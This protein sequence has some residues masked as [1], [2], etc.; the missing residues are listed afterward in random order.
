MFCITSNR[1][2]AEPL[3]AEEAGH[4][5]HGN[6]WTHA[7][8]FGLIRAKGSLGR[9]NYVTSNDPGVRL[10]AQL[11]P[12]AIFITRLDA[13]EPGTGKGGAALEKIKAFA[14]STG[15][16]VDLTAG[17]DTP[18]LQPKLNA[19]YEKHGFTKTGDDEH[20]SYSWNPDKVVKAG[21]G[22]L[23]AGDVSGEARDEKG[24]WTSGISAPENEQKRVDGAYAAGQ[25]AGEKYN[26]LNEYFG[27]VSAGEEE[28]PVYY[29]DETNL[30]SNAFESGLKGLDKLK[31]VTAIRIGKIPE[32]GQSTNFAEQK[33]EP[34]VSV[35]H[36]EG[37]AEKHKGTFEMFNPGTKI[38]VAG[39]L[40]HQ[41]GSD[42]EPLL[43]R[44]RELKSRRAVSPH[45]LEAAG[46]C[47]EINSSREIFAPLEA[48][49][50]DAIDKYVD[51]LMAK[52]VPHVTDDTAEAMKQSLRKYFQK[53]S[54][55][56]I[57]QFTDEAQ[58]VV[59]R[60]LKT[61]QEIRPGQTLSTEVGTGTATARTELTE[62]LEEATGAE[63]PA[64]M[65]M[66][67]F[68]RVAKE[69][70]FGAGRFVGDNGND[71][72]VQAYP[73]LEL[74]RFDHVFVPRGSGTGRNGPDNGWG[75]RFLAA[76]D[77]AGDDAA[78]KVFE[79]TG[80]MV[81]LRD[82]DVWQAL[83]DGAGGYEDTL[84]NPF[85][86]FAWNSGYDT[87]SISRKETIELGLMDE[88][89]DDGNPTEAKPAEVDFE[90][91][92]SGPSD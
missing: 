51:Q 38:R 56:K 49:D 69:V 82:S 54:A 20:P 89:D 91:L 14:Q 37:E 6:Q 61:M 88:L 2:I 44:A 78:A 55:D 87:K 30:E 41:T 80:R 86:P 24:Q 40:H 9:M 1:E 28:L 5:F 33:M 79:E 83:G 72:L 48:A 67:F 43:V 27:A 65:N 3:L 53:V 71:D 25:K 8:S 64:K 57:G 46:R 63:L 26:N 34:G 90:N 68:L 35:L 32:R 70:A 15:R 12:E 60:T 29:N 73:A 22:A 23:E 59:E 21:R 36:L 17:A 19:F 45:P 50:L 62:F 31:Y 4:E 52:D 92:F 81:A 13:V 76:C 84:G 58:A 47:I 75:P 10:S 42:G 11:T 39:W 7:E 74:V 77:E 66:D 85:A 18:D 16:R